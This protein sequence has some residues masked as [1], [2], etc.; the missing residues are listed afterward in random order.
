MPVAKLARARRSTKRRERAVQDSA[1]VGESRLVCVPQC[2]KLLRTLRSG[3]VIGDFISMDIPDERTAACRQSFA[4]ENVD[5]QCELDRVVQLRLAIR[6]ISAT[7]FART[8]F[9]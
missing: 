1:R 7:F 5:V 6:I 2:F 4:F 3:E 8:R 9:D